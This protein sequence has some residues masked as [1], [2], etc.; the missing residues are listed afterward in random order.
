MLRA[1]T[2]P[3]AP[4]Y[5]VLV[6]PGVGI[7]VQVRSAQGG[8]TTKIANPAGTVPVYLKITRSGSTFTAYTSPDGVNWTLI[9]GSS[10]TVNLGTGLLAGLAVTSHNNGTLGTVTMDGVTVG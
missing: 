3:G 4:N 5:A 2:D 9:P 8:T 10:A 6:S 1:T 7:K